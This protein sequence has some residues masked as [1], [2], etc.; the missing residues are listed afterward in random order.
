MLTAGLLLVATV[1][2]LT[3]QPAHPRPGDEVRVRYVPAGALATRSHLR[4][5]FQFR[6]ST[7]L[8][9]GPSAWATAPV[10]ATSMTRSRDGAYVATFRFAS[11]GD[12]ALLAVTDSAESIVDRGSDGGWNVVARE[13]SDAP[14][15]R[16]MVA[17]LWEQTQRNDWDNALLTARTI[18]ATYPS[19]PLGWYVR[20]FVE[21]SALGPVGAKPAFDSLKAG[22]AATDASLRAAS[23]PDADDVASMMFLAQMADTSRVQ[24][25]RSRL[26]HDAPNHPLAVNERV[27]Q[28]SRAGGDSS[29][30]LDSLEAWFASG[31]APASPLTGLGSRLALARGDWARSL[32]WMDRAL[33]TAWEREAT[34]ANAE[35]QRGSRAVAKARLDSMIA[36]PTRWRMAED[37]GDTRVAREARVRAAVAQLQGNFAQSLLSAGDTVAAMRAWNGALA[38]NWQWATARR[39]GRVSLARHD[40]AQA[41]RVL[42]P[43]VIDPASTSGFVDSVRALS[44]ALASEAAWRA[45]RADARRELRLLLAKGQQP[46][47]ALSTARLATL[48]DSAASVVSLRGSGATVI[49]FWS[50]LCRASRDELGPLDQL[51]ARMQD[52]QGRVIVATAEAASPELVSYVTPK[53]GKLAIYHDE[54]A[55]LRRHFSSTGTPEYFVLDERGAAPFGKTNDLRMVGLQVAAL[56]KE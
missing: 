16:G 31:A 23:S 51:R 20:L 55:E 8:M 19:R 43:L 7:D 40:T 22:F 45:F 9:L 49:A 33:A 42:A 35:L 14:G 18:T 11:D 4:L 26:I 30:M 2:T 52:A 32:R 6:R 36:E 24:Y 29:A 25:W 54:F 46:V 28:L 44:P 27:M 21:Q 53:A 17:L 48:G 50:R 56:G 39:L 47:T 15:L 38:A 5:R 10:N 1:S 12:L 34:L 41:L 13:R 37:V 3:V